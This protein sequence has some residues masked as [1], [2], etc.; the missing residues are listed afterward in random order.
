MSPCFI[1]SYTLEM[2]VGTL[3]CCCI[4]ESV[5]GKPRCSCVEKS[6]MTINLGLELS[7]GGGTDV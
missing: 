5:D 3:P 1:V 2:K 4:F 7:L 6:K